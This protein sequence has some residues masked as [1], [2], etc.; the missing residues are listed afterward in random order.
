MRS[1]TYAVWLGGVFP[2]ATFSPEIAADSPLPR[3]VLAG[4]G[5]LTMSVRSPWREVVEL[6]V[7]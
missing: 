6:V 5:R 1:L 2:S 3:Q 4:Q 7:T